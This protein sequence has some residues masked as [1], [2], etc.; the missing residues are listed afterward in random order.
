MKKRLISILLLFVILGA[1]GC[2]DR[3][4]KDVGKGA[5]VVDDMGREVCVN[6]F[7][8]VAALTGSLGEIWMLAGGTLSAVAEDAWSELSLALDENT[9]NLGNSHAISRDILLS[10]TPELV[11]ASSKLASHLELE[12]SL[13]SSG[14]AVLYF[15]VSDLD[16]YLRVLKVFTDITEKTDLYEKNGAAVEEEVKEILLRNKD[17]EPQRVLVLRAS[18][19]SI[20]VKNSDGTMLGG[21]LRDFGCINIADSDKSLLESLSVESIVLNQPDKIFFVQMGEDMD[22][23]KASVEEMFSENP[24]WYELDA[25]KEGRVYYMEKRL[26]NMKPNVRFAEAYAGLE[27][28][29]YEE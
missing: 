17:R 28:I 26:Y 22:A 8:R 1:V 7:S 21:M 3:A 13:R 23:I 18:S 16:D 5:L 6:S 11:I 20:K 19:A 4:K 14:I 12:E 2:D 25:V 10:N 24:L 9:A 15:D 27:K 29:L